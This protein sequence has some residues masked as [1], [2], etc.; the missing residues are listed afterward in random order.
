MSHEIEGFDGSVSTLELKVT[1]PRCLFCLISRSKPKETQFIV[2]KIA[3]NINISEAGR[4]NLFE[5]LFV[6][7]TET[8]NQYLHMNFPLKRLVTSVLAALLL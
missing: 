6:K 7:M 5:F 3:A 4:T 1:S 2:K 8:M